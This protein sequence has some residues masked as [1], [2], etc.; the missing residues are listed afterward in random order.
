MPLIQ[1]NEDM[2]LDFLTVLEKVAPIASPRDD[3]EL[4]ITKQWAQ[5][6]KYVQEISEPMAYEPG[7]DTLKVYWHELE[8]SYRREVR[9]YQARLPGN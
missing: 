8:T 2:L 3:E 6:A 1:I 5:I 9:D 4:A 7:F